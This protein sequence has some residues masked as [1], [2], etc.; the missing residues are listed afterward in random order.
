MSL[1]VASGVLTMP[2]GFWLRPNPLDDPTGE[3]TAIG[4]EDMITDRS[5]TLKISTQE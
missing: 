1:A 3:S 5:V 4:V 2:L